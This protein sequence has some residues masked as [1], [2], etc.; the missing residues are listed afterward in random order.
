MSRTLVA[1][2]SASGRTARLAKALA[3]VTHADLREIRPAQPYSAA[4]LDWHN[5]NSRSSVEMKDTA[6][7]PALGNSIGG[8]EDY[9]T[10]FVGFPI[11]WYEAPR[12]IHTFLESSDFTGKTLIPFATSGSSGM[13]DTDAILKKTCPDAHWLPGRRMNENTSAEE[14]SAWV[15]E[16]GL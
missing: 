2:F 7:R 11:W 3:G 9:D 14:L 16:L 10:I 13:G 15:K 1:Y 5:P 4:D 12:I 6:S 8:I